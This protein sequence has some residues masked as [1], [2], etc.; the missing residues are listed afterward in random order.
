MT[1]KPATSC[2]T[3]RYMARVTAHL[4]A[5]R[6]DT[7]RRDFISREIEK[8]EERYAR[9]MQT[10]GD[11][12]RRGDGPSQPTAF[13]FVETIAALSAVHSRYNGREAA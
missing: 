5:L 9:F 3:T 4:P 13:D 8:W 2:R 11:S 1:A 7:A 12:L 6:D 10:E